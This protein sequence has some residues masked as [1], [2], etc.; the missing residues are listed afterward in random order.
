[1][2][3]RAS[4]F[5]YARFDPDALC[6]LASSL[7][8][9]QSCSCDPTQ[10]PKT[11]SFNWVVFISFVDGVE[12][13]LRSPRKGDG[14][15]SDDTNLLLLASEAATLRYIKSHS[16]IPVPEVYSYQTSADNDVGVPYILMS[17]AGGA[18]LHHAWQYPEVLGTEEQREKILFQLGAI[19]WQLS[20]LRFSQAGSL[21]EDTGEV[22][23][24]T[25]LSRGLL[26]GRRD[27]LE[28]VPRG[29]FDSEDDF[30]EAHVTAFL[31]HV[32]YL[33]LSHHCFLAP[34][35][36]R[37]DYSNETSYLVAVDRWN[38]FVA[39]QSKIDSS[40]NRTDYVIAGDAILSLMATRSQLCGYFCD[41]EH[42]GFVLYHPDLS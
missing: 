15:V 17:K 28:D 38:N 1:M 20:R 8:E 39:V 34:V 31:E 23:I 24:K 16:T 27:D 6:Q 42:H 41:D 12:W 2:Q 40:L 25:C 13:V 19:T 9:G 10:R 30:Y 32:R 21:F 3:E 29:P 11:G 37:R 18:P 35:P 22:K 7:R 5:E 4:I 36:A 33:P 26:M 14:I